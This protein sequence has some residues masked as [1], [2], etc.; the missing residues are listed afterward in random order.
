MEINHPLH[1]GCS[2]GRNR[3]TIRIPQD[4]TERPKVF[5]DSGYGHR[6][7]QATPLSAWLR[8]PLSWYES[9]TY[10]FMD[11]ESHASIRR[12]YTSPSEQSSKRHF[13]GFCGTPLA[14]WSEE[15]PAEAEYISL[16]LGSLAGKDL[17][18]LEDLGVLPRE[19]IEDAESEK[20]VIED[21]A[22]ES[23]SGKA[24]GEEGL[25]WFETMVKGISTIARC[26]PGGG[27]FTGSQG[28]DPGKGTSLHVPPTRSTSSSSPHSTINPAIAQLFA[29]PAPAPGPAPGTWAV[30]WGASN[31]TSRTPLIVDEG[32][33]IIDPVYA[34]RNVGRW[35][36][37]AAAE[38]EEA[39]SV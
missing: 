28:R 20:V 32:A 22:R 11:D 30:E 4:A 5:F 19:A 8:I 38:A 10:A 31:G 12:T 17:R 18:D 26:I 2:C 6:R 9:T 33:S 27:G 34:V 29:P 39:K 37:G 1:G 7:F 15:T 14:F 21:V 24:H 3:Y 23:G 36:S 13:C 35:A 25:P 16:T